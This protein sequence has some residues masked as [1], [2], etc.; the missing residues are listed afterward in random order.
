[1]SVPSKQIGGSQEYYLLWEISKELERI[2]RIAGSSLITT[3]TTTTT[4][5]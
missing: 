1:M 3:T 2:L 4:I 5:P